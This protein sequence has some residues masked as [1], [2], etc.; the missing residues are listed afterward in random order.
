MAGGE[1]E[2][3]TLDAALRLAAPSERAAG[4]G[5]AGPESILDRSAA[6]DGAYILDL[7]IERGGSESLRV[8]DNLEEMRLSLGGR[9]GLPVQ[10]D[11]EPPLAAQ[12]TKTSSP[13]ASIEGQHVIVT[14]WPIVDGGGS[15]T[16]Y[17]GD[18]PHQNGYD[19]P[20]LEPGG[21]GGGGETLPQCSCAGMTPAQ[22]AEQAIDAEAAQIL[23]EI[24]AEANQNMEYGSLIWKDASG[25]LHHTPLIPSPDNMARFDFS[26]LPQ[27]A[28]GTPDYSVIVDFVHSHPEFQPDQFGV[29]ERYFTDADPDYLLYPSQTYTAAN[30]STV[31]DW[32]TWD[33]LGA[34]ILH[35]GGN[36]SN[37]RQYV[38]GFDGTKLVLKEYN[39]ADYGTGSSA[40]GETVDPN[41]QPCTC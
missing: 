7:A 40:G 15:I 5:I 39:A 10:P 37:F 22:K 8:F 20:T 11:A 38:A 13:R 4:I 12:P 1:A 36:V 26:S 3:E 6:F 24:K 14:A 30:G 21:G 27:N 9:H 25:N 28:D 33:G 2:G 19:H 41:T 35:D 18:G 17:T 31:G 34:N 16:L 29:P 23:A 32:L